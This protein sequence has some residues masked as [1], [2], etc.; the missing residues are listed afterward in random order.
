MLLLGRRFSFPLH[1]PYLEVPKKQLHL[2]FLFLLLFFLIFLIIKEEE[3]DK[4]VLKETAKEKKKDKM[5]R[6]FKI[7]VPTV[8]CS[9]KLQDLGSW[10]RVCTQKSD[11]QI[12][13][14]SHC[15]NS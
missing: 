9:N 14:L 12:S 10:L 7:F 15:I 1:G 13:K 8:Q 2:V 4:E 3:E 5:I 11:D 6:A